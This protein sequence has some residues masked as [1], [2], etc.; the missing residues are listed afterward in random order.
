M[1]KSDIIF[2]AIVVV[3]LL[4]NSCFSPK[5]SAE[6]ENVLKSLG[7]IQNSL[8]AN[9]SYDQYAELL[10]DAKIQVDGLKQSEQNNTC[11]ISAFVWSVMMRGPVT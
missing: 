3:M 4:L 7:N 5:K 10:V 1:R 9:I 2:S 8:E 6:E 11:F